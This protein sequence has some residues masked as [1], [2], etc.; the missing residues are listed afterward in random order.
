M[1]H[2]TGM[3]PFGPNGINSSAEIAIC[4]KP[5]NW[6]KIAAGRPTIDPGLVNRLPQAVW[7]VEYNNDCERLKS[8][9]RKWDLLPPQIVNVFQKL[10]HPDFITQ[11]AK[12]FQIDE[13]VDDPFVHGGGL[14]VVWPGGSLQTHVDY[15]IHPK[16]SQFER[17]IN[18]IQFLH[19]EWNPNWGGELV[20]LDPADETTA[21]V[22]PPTPGS[23]VAFECGPVSFHRVNPVHHRGM[24]R[25]TAAVYFLAPKRPTATRTRALFIPNRGT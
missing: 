11:I 22:I 12:A 24:P 6:A 13:L 14:H 21:A 17:R 23:I 25:V 20:L 3:K 5:F 19:N 16:L 8:T 9:S 15:E 10:R 1:R 18:V 4:G 2:D 7:E